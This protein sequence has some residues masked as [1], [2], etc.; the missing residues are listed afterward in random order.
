MGENTTKRV[1][2]TVNSFRILEQLLEAKQ[3]MG[4]TELA[5]AV[6]LSKGV[7]YTHLSTLSELGYIKKEEQRYLPSLGLLKL[8]EDAR[9]G[10]SVFTQARHHIENLARVTGEVSTLFIEEDGLGVCVYTAVGNGSWM[11]DYT[12]GSRMPLHVN[13][14]GKAILASLEQ[15]RV[16]DIIEEHGLTRMTNETVTIPE[17]LNSELRNISES[18][19]SFS[20]GEQFVDVVGVATTIDLDGREPVAAI[21][22]CGPSS[23]LNGRYLEEDIT[24]Q[25]ISTAKSIQVDLAR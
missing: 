20:R 9:R 18:G 24:G 22:V 21:G 8:G 3:S 11:P 25:V 6:G 7:V 2:A 23:R 19:V 14:T 13:A 5:D 10:L 12:C 17:T 4:V 1:Q 15:D 16:D